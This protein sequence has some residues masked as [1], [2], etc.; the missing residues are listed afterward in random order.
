MRP[1][2]K[3]CFRRGAPVVH[4]WIC[5]LLLC[6]SQSKNPSSY[7]ELRLG[8][9]KS[10]LS[11]S[12]I[13]AEMN[14]K[15]SLEVKEFKACLWWAELLLVDP[16]GSP[17]FKLGRQSSA[18][19]RLREWYFFR[20]LALV[21]VSPAATCSMWT[22]MSPLVL[23]NNWKSFKTTM[24]AVLW[25]GDDNLGV[26]LLPAPIRVLNVDIYRV[27]LKLIFPLWTEPG[28]WSMQL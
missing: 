15:P 13:S 1:N 19:K 10:F 18:C 2:I 27:V 4:W 6:P 26:L 23:R 11:I 21:L 12:L 17:T 8:S 24:E 28:T 9:P 7:Q 3:I 22:W 14:I 20:L 5:N 16:T 25:N